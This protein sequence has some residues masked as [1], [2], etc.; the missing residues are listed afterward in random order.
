MKIGVLALQGAFIEHIKMLRRL[1][2]EAVEVRLPHQ[3]D[4]LDGLIIPGGESTTIGK[5][6]TSYGLIEP[7]RRFARN[8]ADLGHLRRHDLPGEGHRH[9]RTADPGRH[10]IS[11]SIATLSAARSTAS[12][13]TWTIAGLA[14]GPFHA[15]FIRAPVVTAVEAPVDVLARLD[16]GRIVAVRQGQLLATAFHPEL[17]D[18][19]RLHCI[20]L[21]YSKRGTARLSPGRETVDRDRQSAA[22]ARTRDHAKTRKTSRRPSILD[23]LMRGAQTSLDHIEE[24]TAADLAAIDEVDDGAPHRARRWMTQSSLRPALALTGRGGRAGTGFP[25]RLWMK[26]MSSASAD[27]ELDEV[28]EL[29]EDVESLIEDYIDVE[30]DDEELDDEGYDLDD[31]DDDISSYHDLYGDDDTII[32]SLS[33]RRVRGR[34]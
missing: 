5:L 1:G 22:P 13:P 3:L 15:V 12:K 4:G 18:D 32:P 2:V 25:G 31:D 6:A 27:D 33:R 26:P 34:R 20:I 17:T 14:G 11:P 28:D 9:R 23:L 16:D 19:L 30:L 24:P 21:R 8:Q 7:L 10:G 29:L